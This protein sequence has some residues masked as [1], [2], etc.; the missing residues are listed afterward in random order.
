LI[1]FI[2]LHLFYFPSR[3]RPVAERIHTTYRIM[4]LLMTLGELWRSF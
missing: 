3:N 4:T 1:D 2:P